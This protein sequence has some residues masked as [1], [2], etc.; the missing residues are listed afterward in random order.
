MP[1]IFSFAKADQ[2]TLTS[3]LGFFFFFTI[4]ILLFLQVIM[5]R[6]SISLE[7]R[8]SREHPVMG[9]IYS[10]CTFQ[11]GPARVTG[12]LSTWSGVSATTEQSFN[13]ESFKF[14]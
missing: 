3:N 13:F 11:H 7:E 6:K 5:Q 2:G 4:C 12:L 8:Y 14:K 1:R 10:I 9:E